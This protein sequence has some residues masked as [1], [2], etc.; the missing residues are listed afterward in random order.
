MLFHGIAENLV[1]FAATPIMELFLL[2]KSI[3][4]FHALSAEHLHKYALW[5]AYFTCI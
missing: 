4:T 5:E 2:Q 1:Y 3:S